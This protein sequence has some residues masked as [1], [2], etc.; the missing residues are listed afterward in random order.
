[1]FANIFGWI[2]TVG[3]MFFYIPQLISLIRAP[4]VEGFNIFAWSCLFVAVV[5]LA[6]GAALTGWW[7]GA[8]ANG[9]SIVCVAASIYYMRKKSR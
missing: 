4:H 5:A 9:L 6:L 7:S 8:I 2:G 3:L 1:M